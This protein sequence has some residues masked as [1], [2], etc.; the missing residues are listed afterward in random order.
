MEQR[1]EVGRG[2]RNSLKS[3]VLAYSPLCAMYGLYC[4]EQDY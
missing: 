3:T 4:G 2:I 1:V